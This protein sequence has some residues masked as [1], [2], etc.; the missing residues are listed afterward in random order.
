MES[1]HEVGSVISGE[2]KEFVLDGVTQLVNSKS[3]TTKEIIKWVDQLDTLL[4]QSPSMKITISC[5]CDYISSAALL[6]QRPHNAL[7]QFMSELQQAYNDKL[8]KTRSK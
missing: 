1:E 7:G 5:L 6:Q 8:A 3:P 2:C 4:T